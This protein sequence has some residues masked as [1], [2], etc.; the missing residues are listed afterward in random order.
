M[1]LLICPLIRPFGPPS[2]QGEGLSP[3][4]TNKEDACAS[5][6]IILIL[7]LVG[8][9]F[10]ADHQTA[11]FRVE[12]AQA[13]GMTDGHF[14]TGE[15]LQDGILQ[16]VGI[17][18]T[19]AVVDADLLAGLQATLFHHLDKGLGGLLLAPGLM[20]GNDLT[21]LHIAHGTDTQNTGDGG[22]SLAD[23]AVPGQ[24]R[25]TLQAEQ[26]MGVGVIFLQLLTGGGK[27]GAGIHDLLKLIQQQAHFGTG[28]QAV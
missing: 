18:Q 1:S 12:A 21:V 2:P 25:Q 3:H 8:A 6:F 26:D 28:G 14:H 7:E 11:D 23:A 10:Q 13:G 20:Y 15:V 24:V 17:L 4:L 19:E 27:I 5:S 22:S 16:H 9:A